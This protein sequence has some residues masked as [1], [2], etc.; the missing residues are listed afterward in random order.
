[1]SLKRIIENYFIHEGKIADKILPFYPLKRIRDERERYLP[2]G[3]RASP[4]LLAARIY[5]AAAV[6]YVGHEMVKQTRY[7]T[8]SVQQP[9]YN[10]TEG[11]KLVY[12]KDDIAELLER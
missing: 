4:L 8:L 12:N 3:K 1:M 7:A 9:R 2:L 5:I 6:L 10:Y 11:Q